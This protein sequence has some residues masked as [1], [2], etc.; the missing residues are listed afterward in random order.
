MVDQ[1]LTLHLHVGVDPNLTISVA[2][3]LVLRLEQTLRERLPQIMEVHCHLE[4][5]NSIILPSARVSTGLQ[6]RVCF[7]VEQAVETIPHL[8]HPHDIQVRQVEGRLFITLSVL[9]NN[10]LSAGEA[11]QLST[12]LQESVRIHLP[13]VGETLVRL[14]PTA[15]N[16]THTLHEVTLSKPQKVLLNGNG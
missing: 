2:H 15:G 10:T 4:P 12:R 8:D 14:E 5:A 11:Y 7:V 16:Y 3:D 13:D 1:Q 6:Q 9:V